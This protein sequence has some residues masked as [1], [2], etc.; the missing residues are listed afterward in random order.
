MKKKNGTTKLS[1]K[2]IRI[3][4][5]AVQQTTVINGGNVKTNNTCPGIYPT[6]ELGCPLQTC[7]DGG[8]SFCVGHPVTKACIPLTEAQGCSNYGCPVTA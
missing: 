1:L 2:K 6:V 5:L 3:A 4:S 7:Q 8:A